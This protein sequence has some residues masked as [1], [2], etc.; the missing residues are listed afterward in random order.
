MSTANQEAI[1]NKLKLKSI[2]EAT[3]FAKNHPQALLTLGKNGISLPKIRDHSAKLLSA[4]TLTAMLLAAPV[5]L[6]PPDNS[7]SLPSQATKVELPQDRLKSRLNEVLPQEV[8][9][10]TRQEEKYLEVAFKD[11]VGIETRATLEG[12][13]LN[14]TYGKIGLEQHL[15]R[16]PGDTLDQHKVD[17]TVRNA[18]IAPG[19]GAWG[20]FANS[21]E[22]LTPDLVE[23]EKWYAVVQTMYLPDW[24]SRHHYLRDWY[25]YRKVLIV[26]TTNGNAVVAAIADAGP[27][28]WTGKHF[29]GSPEVMDHLGGARYTKGNV[30]MFFVDDPNNQIPLGPIEYNKTNMLINQS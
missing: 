30:V 16:Y 17:P 14:T 11:L 2:N 7:H 28:A 5:L 9:P 8:R 20:Y 29:G 27:A 3:G 25:K 21:K 13:H 23:T 1:R 4:G 24:K 15:R 6:P 26:N 12:E 19:L 10:L 18:G 22:E